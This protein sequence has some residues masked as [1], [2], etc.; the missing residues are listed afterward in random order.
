[1]MI[2]LIE[3]SREAEENQRYEGVTEREFSDGNSDFGNQAAILHRET[4][5]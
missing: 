5:T 3:Q 4:H 1:M 2:E